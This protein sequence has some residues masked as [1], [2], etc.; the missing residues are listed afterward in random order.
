MMENSGQ[1]FVTLFSDSPCCGN[2]GVSCNGD[3][4]TME[5][6]GQLWRKSHFDGYDL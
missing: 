5:N 1:T 2:E 3:L 6:D 4:E